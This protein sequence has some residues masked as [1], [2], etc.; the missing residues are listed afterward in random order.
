M[1]FF[2]TWNQQGSEATT[3][4]YFNAPQYDD[5]YITEMALFDIPREICQEQHE[6]KTTETQPTIMGCYKPST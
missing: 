1:N 6:E 3:D 4:Y 2:Q 5:K